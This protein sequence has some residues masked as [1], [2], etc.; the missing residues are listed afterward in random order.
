MQPGATAFGG[1]TLCVSGTVKRT[2]GQLSGG[3]ATLPCSGSFDFHLGHAYLAS[4][5]LAAG[6]T[7]HAQYWSRDPGFAAPNNISLTDALEVTLVP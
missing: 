7:V 5:G 2:P 6:T 1:G 3:L 4:Q